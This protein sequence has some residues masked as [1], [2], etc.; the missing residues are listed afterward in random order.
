VFEPTSDWGEDA[1]G[2][3]GRVAG[4]TVGFR[5]AA[6]VVDFQKKKARQIQIRFDGAQ[7]TIPTGAE[8]QRSKTNYLLV[9]RSGALAYSYSELCEGDLY[10]LVSQY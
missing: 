10:R 4:M 7:P 2:M 5:P 3:V 8:L 6:V 9:Q 1:I